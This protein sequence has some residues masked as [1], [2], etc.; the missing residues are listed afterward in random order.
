MN[1]RVES[2]YAVGLHKNMQRC[3]LRCNLNTFAYPK[4]FLNSAIE[5]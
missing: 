1:G 4:R 2:E 5:Y 3:L